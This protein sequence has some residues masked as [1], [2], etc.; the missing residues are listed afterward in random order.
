MID[1]EQNRARG[2]KKSIQLYY[3][4]MGPHSIHYLY[5]RN[6]RRQ[7]AAT[8]M[9]QEVIQQPNQRNQYDASIAKTYQKPRP[10]LYGN[11][12]FLPLAPAVNEYIDNYG[13]VHINTYQYQPPK[14][15]RR[16]IKILLLASRGE[17]DI[18]SAR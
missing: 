8:C 6:D 1:G 12:H 5:R 13:I 4:F 14:R 17:G 16:H 3:F 15:R 2:K 18:R 7:S 9:M 10:K 11:G